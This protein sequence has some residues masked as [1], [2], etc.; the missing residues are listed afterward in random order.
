M[1]HPR[2]SLVVAGAVVGLGAAVAIPLAISP[3][4]F[5][6][7]G[8]PAA[9]PTVVAVAP[10][11]PRAIERD[12]PQPAQPGVR[13]RVTAPATHAA[14]RRA[15]IVRPER[16]APRDRR[17]AGTFVAQS[18]AARPAP[19]RASQPSSRPARHGA[20]AEAPALRQTPTGQPSSLA[21]QPPTAVAQAP[22]VAVSAGFGASGRCLATAATACPPP[23]AA[24]GARPP[25]APAAAWMAPRA[26]RPARQV[27]RADHA[28]RAAGEALLRM[29]S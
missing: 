6:F 20:P 24:I 21:Q 3:G 28:V 29:R 4:A 15:A 8:W 9:P 27:P 10:V 25:Q 11:A 12:A 22:G 2:N 16:A 14:G 19:R 17:P 18:G 23:T 13:V 26:R 5:R 1:V 7:D